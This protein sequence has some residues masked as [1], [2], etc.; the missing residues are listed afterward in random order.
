MFMSLL[1]SHVNNG[2][3]TGALPTELTCVSIFDLFIYLLFLAY[4][5]RRLHIA[6]VWPRAYL[7]HVPSQGCGWSQ[8]ERRQHC[9]LRYTILNSHFPVAL[10]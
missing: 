1:P 5:L 4:I 10:K 9:N 7:S 6:V 8:V 2:Q 3:Q